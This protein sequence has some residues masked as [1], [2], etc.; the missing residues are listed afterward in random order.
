MSRDLR[1]TNPQLRHIQHMAVELQR[2]GSHTNVL[3]MH[4]GEVATWVEALCKCYCR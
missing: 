3:A 4:P 1:Q 2:N